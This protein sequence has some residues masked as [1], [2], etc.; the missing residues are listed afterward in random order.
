M[1]LLS[2]SRRSLCSKRETACLPWHAAD[3]LSHTASASALAAPVSSRCI[4][5]IASATRRDSHWIAGLGTPCLDNNS[6]TNLSTESKNAALSDCAT[7]SAP[8]MHPALGPPHDGGYI[9][10]TTAACQ[11]GWLRRRGIAVAK[12]WSES[13][14]NCSESDTSMSATFVCKFVASSPVARSTA[15]ASS[16]SVDTSSKGAAPAWTMQFSICIHQLSD[17]VEDGEMAPLEPRSSLIMVITSAAAIPVKQPAAVRSLPAF[18][19]I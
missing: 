11:P 18:F 12:A 1:W 19:K 2:A 4:L 7:A 14:S 9:L 5:T 16:S 8:P 6:L 3:A 13:V 15:S 10:L 17:S